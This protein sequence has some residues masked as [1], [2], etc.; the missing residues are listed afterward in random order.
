[1]WKIAAFSGVEIITYAVMSNHFHILVRVPVQQ[2]ISDDVFINRLQQLY[3][4]AEVA[5]VQKEMEDVVV[6]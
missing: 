3:T 6:R 5:A 2:D 1:M 4:P